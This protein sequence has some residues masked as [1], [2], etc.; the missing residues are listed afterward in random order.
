MR[1]ANTRSGGKHRHSYDP[2]E[3]CVRA[4]VDEVVASAAAEEAQSR[5]AQRE[6]NRETREQA[7]K[8]ALVNKQEAQRKNL[9][10]I[11]DEAIAK[12]LAAGQCFVRLKMRPLTMVRTDC[13]APKR[14]R[15]HMRTTSWVF[16]SECDAWRNPVELLSPAQLESGERHVP[17]CAHHCAMVGKACPPEP[18]EPFKRWRIAPPPPP[19][20]PPPRPPSPSL[21]A[22]DAVTDGPPWTRTLATRCLLPPP[23]DAAASITAAVARAAEAQWLAESPRDRV[24]R[25]A[26]HARKHPLGMIDEVFYKHL[27]DHNVEAGEARD[28]LL[29]RKRLIHNGKSSAYELP[30][31]GNPI[32]GS[33]GDV[34][35]R[36]PP[37]D[38]EEPLSWLRDPWGTYLKTR[39]IARSGLVE[40]LS[41]F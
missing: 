25:Q 20:P 37:P 17:H 26:E 18:H 23:A 41:A 40:A 27:R 36:A 38:G 29:K 12:R 32:L 4:L 34:A 3:Q 22:L 33:S 8:Q 30:A 28:E 21:S 24:E 39:P 19:P 13:A 15:A 9:R 31:M 16:C 1:G 14:K 10:H 11:H 5:K 6:A 2:V 7:R 35:N